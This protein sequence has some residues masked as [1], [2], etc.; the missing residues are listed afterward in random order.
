MADVIKKATRDG[1]EE[2]LKFGKENG[3]VFKALNEK[4][5]TIQHG[6]GN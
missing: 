5:P 2:I 3:Y 6:I 1:L 4:S